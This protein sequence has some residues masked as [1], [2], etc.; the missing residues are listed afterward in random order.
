M[1]IYDDIAGGV[2]PAGDGPSRRLQTSTGET[3]CSTEGN[4]ARRDARWMATGTSINLTPPPRGGGT[5]PA[6]T[7]SEKWAR[8]ATTTV[9]DIRFAV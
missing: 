5:T 8:R 9:S 3:G 1:N 2:S 7:A 4:R 6:S